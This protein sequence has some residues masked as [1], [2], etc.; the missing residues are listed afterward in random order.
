MLKTKLKELTAGDRFRTLLTNRRGE[1]Q[2]GHKVGSNVDGVV[3]H[4]DDELFD[5]TLHEDVV[6]ELTVN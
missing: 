3:V 6:V 1:V 4:F 5:K 2:L